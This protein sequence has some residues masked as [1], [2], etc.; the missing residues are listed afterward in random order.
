MFELENLNKEI[1]N[2]KKKN[3]KKLPKRGGVT[4]LIRGTRIFF[5]KFMINVHYFQLCIMYIN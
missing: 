4:L 2:Q 5:V 1:Q 3:P